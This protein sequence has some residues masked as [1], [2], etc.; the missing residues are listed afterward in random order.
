MT[1]EL[2]YPAGGGRPHVLA[3][4]GG[5]GALR[6]ASTSPP[7]YDTLNGLLGDLAAIDVY[8]GRCPCTTDKEPPT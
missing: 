4:D 7:K 1:A 8:K 6:L 5:M 2:H 3:D